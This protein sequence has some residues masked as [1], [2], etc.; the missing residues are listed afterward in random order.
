MAGNGYGGYRT[1]VEKMMR[2]HDALPRHLRLLDCYTVAKW[3]GDSLPR[4]WADTPPQLPPG[5]R[6]RRVAAR[7]AAL[8]AEDT[9]KDYGPAHP[10]CPPALRGKPAPKGAW[11]NTRRKVRK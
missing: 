4:A 6:L 1:T 3:A 10:E 2:E 9:F 5:E 7:L 11:W 8:D